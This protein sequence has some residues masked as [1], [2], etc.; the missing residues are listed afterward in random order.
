MK[1]YK[2]RW[3]TSPIW[4]PLTPSKQA[5][6]LPINSPPTSL[7]PYSRP[8]SAVNRMRPLFFM[9]FGSNVVEISKTGHRNQSLNMK[10]E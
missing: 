6:K 4:G 10:R 2:D 1:V 5:L 7:K 9:M 8:N 3:A